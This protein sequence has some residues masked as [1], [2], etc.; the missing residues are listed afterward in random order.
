VPGDA[1]ECIARC[2]K[3]ARRLKSGKGYAKY[4]VPPNDKCRQKMA[5]RRRDGAASGR[6]PGELVSD[7]A[8]AA[9]QELLRDELRP[10]VRE[11]IT[12]DVLE[13][14]RKLIG[15]VPKAVEV[16]AALLTSDD[17]KTRFDAAALI[18]RHTTGN[19]NIV[20]DVNEGKHQA[21][22]VV[23]GIP[24]PQV[25]EGEIE[26]GVIETKECDSC[27]ESKPNDAE[28]FVGNSDRC[29]T[30]FDRMRQIGQGIVERTASD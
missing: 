19:K 15:H 23:F 24:R 1:P 28:H 4:C 3:P 13:G 14:V 9:A 18:L 25:V 17:E 2:G 10:V 16:A 7:E 11:A 22:T 20:P 8:E 27:G 26:G 21:M 12:E 6:T 29:V 5:A 30:C